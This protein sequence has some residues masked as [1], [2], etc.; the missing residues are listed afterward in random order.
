MQ[1][2]SKTDE[3]EIT[4]EKR[5]F[6]VLFIL[7]EE[8]FF[9]IFVLS[10]FI[11]YWIHFLNI[12]TFT[13]QKALL[14]TLFCL[15]L[16]LLKAFSVSLRSKKESKCPFLGKKDPYNC[17][18]CNVTVEQRS[19]ILGK[20]RLCHQDILLVFCACHS[21][22]ECS[23]Q[24]WFA[25]FSLSGYFPF[26]EFPCFVYFFG[27][28]PFY[29]HVLSFSENVTFLSPQKILHSLMVSS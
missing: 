9:N 29:C 3:L 12:R 8:N 5:A 23:F 7:F 11:V 2:T 24:K 16:R 21:P 4:E 17:W 15:F 27:V 20:K 28:L 6:F 1:I 13:Y 18:Q 25:Y 26:R 14:H 19:K 22:W 10:Q